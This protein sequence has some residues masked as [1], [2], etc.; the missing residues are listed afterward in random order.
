MGAASCGCC[1]RGRA[2][3]RAGLPQ[4]TSVEAALAPPSISYR[5]GRRCR[6]AEP[7]PPYPPTCPNIRPQISYG[8]SLAAILKAQVGRGQRRCEA[9][10]GAWWMHVGAATHACT[11][12][13]PPHP[14]PTPTHTHAPTVC[15]QQGAA[16]RRR[17]RARAGGGAAAP[18]RPRSGAGAQAAPAPAPCLRLACSLLCTG[19]MF[20]VCKCHASHAAM[21]P[22]PCR[23]C[24]TATS[25]AWQIRGA[26]PPP[27][28]TPWTSARPSGRTW[29]G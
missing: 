19:C 9:G 26:C 13:P 22:P 15:A 5:R 29:S 18:R 28:P 2:G 27:P 23:C 3:S 10:G 17:R 6:G 1:R 20:S 21:P 24:A 12:V 8:L 25:P 14:T 16:R 4:A 11:R 7:V